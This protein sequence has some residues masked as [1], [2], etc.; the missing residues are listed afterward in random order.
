MFDFEDILNEITESEEY[1]KYKEIGNIL[2]NDSFVMDLMNEIKELQHESLM[3][4]YNNDPKYL[5]MEEIIKEKVDILN[6][7]ETYKMYL[8]KMKE[9]NSLIASSTN[10][11]N[12]SVEVL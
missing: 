6:N 9:Y 12:N 11:F 7:N 1:L 8:Q 10:L 3:L 2:E 5:E 4:E